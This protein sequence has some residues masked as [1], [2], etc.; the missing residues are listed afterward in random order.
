MRPQPHTAPPH[1]AADRVPTD[2]GSSTATT[3]LALAIGGVL[4]VVLVL[5]LIYMFVLRKKYKSIK[6]QKK[7]AEYQ[8][9]I[10]DA[11]HVI[12]NM[13]I[14]ETCNLYAN[15]TD[16]QKLVNTVRARGKSQDP[17]PVPPRSLKP[18]LNSAPS[19]D[20]MNIGFKPDGDVAMRPPKPGP[21][22]YKPPPLVPPYET[23]V[24]NP[25]LN[26][27]SNHAYSY[28]ELDMDSTENNSIE[29][30]FLIPFKTMPIEEAQLVAT[31]ESSESSITTTS[32]SPIARPKIGLSKVSSTSSGIVA[33]ISRPAP[34]P[35]A[36]AVTG[37]KPSVP[38][39]SKPIPPMPPTNQKPFTLAPSINS[40]PTAVSFI[41]PS[42]L[43]SSSII[44][45]IT[46]KP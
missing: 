37:P 43:K 29:P 23:V 44:P 13:D 19:S 7:A 25:D 22:S 11:V 18:A 27:E 33:A 28:I 32:I 15:T 21:S 10:E 34:P 42:N 39:N 41:S 40:K 1:D 14:D 4:A 38:K 16:L 31:T 9:R 3:V 8:V 12:N 2:S 5:V 17:L 20:S 26:S 46:P 45:K 36:H 35:P 24:L 6:T 30:E